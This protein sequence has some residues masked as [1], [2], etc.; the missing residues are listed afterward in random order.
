MNFKNYFSNLKKL[1]LKDRNENKGIMLDGGDSCIV[2]TDSWDYRYFSVCL[3]YR[4]TGERIL[5][6]DA[7]LH[8]NTSVFSL[9]GIANGFSDYNLTS[10]DVRTIFQ[11]TDDPTNLSNY[12]CKCRIKQDELNL[13]LSFD[14]PIPLFDGNLHKLVVVFD[15]KIIRFYDN[16]I[17][18]YT[19]T[20]NLDT[21]ELEYS[22][23]GIFNIFHART[24]DPIRIIYGNNN[25]VSENKSKP[26]YSKLYVF[27]YCI[28]LL[29]D[30]VTSSLPSFE[31]YRPYTYTLTDYIN[32]KAIPT[33]MLNRTMPLSTLGNNCPY[34]KYISGTKTPGT[35]TYELSSPNS[36]LT[37]E[38]SKKIFSATDFTWSQIDIGIAQGQCIYNLLG[39]GCTIKTVFEYTINDLINTKTGESPDFSYDP[40]GNVGLSLRTDCIYINDTSYYGTEHNHSNSTNFK[41]VVQD[42]DTGEIIASKYSSGDTIGFYKNKAYYNKKL[43]L[44][45]WQSINLNALTEKGLNAGLTFIPKIIYNSAGQTYKSTFSIEL[46]DYTV[47]GCTL[48]IDNFE[49]TYNMYDTSN[50]VCFKGS[51]GIELD[52]PFTF[53]DPFLTNKDTSVNWPGFISTDQTI[54]SEKWKIRSG[55]PSNNYT[56]SFIKRENFQNDT[57]LQN[58]TGT[59]NALKIS[60]GG[61]P[62]YNGGA[63]SLTPASSESYTYSAKFWSCFKSPR[64]SFD[65]VFRRNT[66][67]PSYIYNSATLSNKYVV[68]LSCLF[69]LANIPN[70]LQ[71]WLHFK[72]KCAGLWESDTYLSSMT[73]SQINSVPPFAVSSYV[74][75][76]EE[77][78]YPGNDAGEE[79][80]TNWHNENATI[81][82]KF[83]ISIEAYGVNDIFISGNDHLYK[84]VNI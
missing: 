10:R 77:Y 49:N 46:K 70:E 72:G 21:S 65:I 52:S 33:H 54:T 50:I 39:P 31:E 20:I 37:S 38:D 76:S 73:L 78:N 28:D 34:L 59:T 69:N 9:R 44:T 47:F 11:L 8:F 48:A 83:D 12:N 79:A 62:N 67:A 36:T 29:D 6:S 60:I 19:Y 40:F 82:A 71:T 84:I 80:L 66:F 27:S 1:F 17:L 16:G 30:I 7:D 26:I 5:N 57:V 22:Q 24:L 64:I 63:Y 61:Y 55:D 14:V 35:G 43:R 25:L 15:Y 81:F 13:N 4:F 41:L 45:V 53:T 68:L 3:N 2:S 51:K 23:K 18:K 58:L 75:K 42:P 56:T 74:P 32:D